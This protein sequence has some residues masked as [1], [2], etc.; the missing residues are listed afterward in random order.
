MA[1]VISTN[2]NDL[3]TVPDSPSLLGVGSI[4]GEVWQGGD[5]GDN[6]REALSFLGGIHR[7]MGR[8]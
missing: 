8:L 3:Q 1:V 7:I 5:Y 6:W 4:N 2:A